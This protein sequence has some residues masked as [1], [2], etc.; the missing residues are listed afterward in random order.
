MQVAYVSRN[1]KMGLF[2]LAARRAGQAGYVPNDF[3]KALLTWSAHPYIQS[4]QAR[5]YTPT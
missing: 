2:D 4:D 5:F 1:D 3:R